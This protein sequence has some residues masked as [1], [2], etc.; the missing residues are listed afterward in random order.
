MQ[1]V[2]RKLGSRKFWACLLGVAVGLG[3]VF[4]LDEGAV[5]DVAGMVTALAALVSYIWAVGRV[6]AASAGETGRT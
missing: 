5:T 3:A 4:G 1:E 2:K 6:D